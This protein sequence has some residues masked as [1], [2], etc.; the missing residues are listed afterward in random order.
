M[1]DRYGHDK[2]YGRIN[3]DHHRPFSLD[4]LRS[5]ASNKNVNL[6]LHGHYHQPL[7]SRH[8]DEWES[9]ISNNRKF[10][11]DNDL[12]YVNDYSFPSG[13]YTLK[14]IKWAKKRFD[15][16]YTINGGTFKPGDNVINRITLISPSVSGRSLTEQIDRSVSN[17]LLPV[18]KRNMIFLQRLKYAYIGK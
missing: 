14:G 7:I 18:V 11:I 16:V 12:K 17:S 3:N 10:F 9:E 5:F 1:Y 15:R 6:G 8:T 2:F 4:E 13:I